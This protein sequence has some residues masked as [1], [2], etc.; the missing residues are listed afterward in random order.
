MART[1]NAKPDIQQCGVVNLSDND[2]SIRCIKE[3]L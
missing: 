2:E 1:K 3:L